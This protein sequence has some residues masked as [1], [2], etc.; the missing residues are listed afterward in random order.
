MCEEILV[1]NSDSNLNCG[2]S[3][4]S[5]SDC[6]ISRDNCNSKNDL[7]SSKYCMQNCIIIIYMLKEISSLC[8]KSLQ[9]LRFLKES[10]SKRV[11][12][13]ARTSVTGNRP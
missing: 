2:N 12:T 8:V 9:E 6:V 11:S 7:L 5:D 13:D 10:T 1:R 4:F 3:D